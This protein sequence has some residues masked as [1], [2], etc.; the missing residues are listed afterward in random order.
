MAR[1]VFDDAKLYVSATPV[2]ATTPGDPT[3]AEIETP[4][5]TEVKIARNVSIN[6][7]RGQID[8]SGRGDDWNQYAAGRTD[9]TVEFEMLV[10]KSNS[11]YSILSTAFFAKS[12][13]AI[14]ALD[15]DK[16]T[17]GSEGI[18]GNFVLTNFT[19]NEQ[20]QEAITYSVTASPSSDNVWYEKAGA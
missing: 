7:E 8:V 17:T 14:M 5:Y 3:D 6:L 10:D 9:G 1:L 4:T 15:G 20:D 2:S 16:A 19:R 18:A 13:I 11:E 12:E